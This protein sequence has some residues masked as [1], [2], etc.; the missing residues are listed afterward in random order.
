VFETGRLAD[1]AISALGRIRGSATSLLL[2]LLQSQDVGKRASAAKAL[3][4][5]ENP[6]ASVM[7]APANALENEAQEVR[8]NAVHALDRLGPKAAGA[9]WSP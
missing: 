6:D 5:V 7:A 9:R 8:E 2:T 1:M 4:Y 3:G